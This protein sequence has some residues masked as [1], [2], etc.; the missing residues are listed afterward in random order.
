MWSIFLQEFFCLSLYVL[1]HLSAVHFSLS[2][3]RR[4]HWGLRTI[5]HISSAFLMLGFLHSFI[6]VLFLSFFRGGIRTYSRCGRTLSVH[7]YGKKKEEEE[8]QRTTRQR[9][10]EENKIHALLFLLRFAL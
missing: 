2:L 1:T 8:H 10:R 3:I 9:K 7:C 4:L 5:F 6:A